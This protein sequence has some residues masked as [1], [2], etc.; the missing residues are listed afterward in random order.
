MC[1]GGVRSILL[2]SLLISLCMFI[3]SKAL[4]ISS[5]TVIV[6]AGGAILS[7]PFAT[8]FLTVCSATPVE[9]CVLDPC[10][11]GGLV[12]LLLCNEEDS[13]PVTLKLLR[14]GIWACMRC[15]CLCWVWGGGSMLTNFHMCGIMLVLR[16]VFNMLA[17]NASPRGSMCCRCLILIC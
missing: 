10:F 2:L 17:R 5:A 6:R 13:S 9:C 3:V 16:A 14:G 11:V 7:N 12:C 1:R 8:V 4:L 15:S